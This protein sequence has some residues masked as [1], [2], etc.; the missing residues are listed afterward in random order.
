MD[1]INLTKIL[2]DAA[3]RAMYLHFQWIELHDAE[4]NNAHA[5]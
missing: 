1:G 3:L 2:P 4:R 5:G